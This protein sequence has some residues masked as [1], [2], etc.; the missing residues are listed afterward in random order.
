MLTLQDVF[1]S[2]YV[3]A[4]VPLNCGSALP[5]TQ[6]AFLTLKSRDNYFR[7]ICNNGDLHY[8]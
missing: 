5:F 2:T 8:K 4:E 1:Q 6:P 3:N 7:A